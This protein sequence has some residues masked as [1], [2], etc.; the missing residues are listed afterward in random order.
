[1]AGTPARFGRC[2]MSTG[3]LY[4]AIPECREDPPVTGPARHS[5]GK[6]SRGRGG[7]PLSTGG[8]GGCVRERRGSRRWLLCARPDRPIARSDSVRSRS[9]FNNGGR[10]PRDALVTVSYFRERRPGSANAASARSA[11][12]SANYDLAPLR[13]RLYFAVGKKGLLSALNQSLLVHRARMPIAVQHVERRPRAAGRGSGSSGW[14]CRGTA[15]AAR[16]SSEWPRGLSRRT[17]ASGR[18]PK[19]SGCSK[20]RFR[21]SGRRASFRSGRR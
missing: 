12:G 4:L 13:K 1:M 6:L 5:R 10:F 14:S 20:C 19:R 15:R 9:P 17:R 3:Q 8:P 21:S 18:G 2:W 11:P 16:G 7:R